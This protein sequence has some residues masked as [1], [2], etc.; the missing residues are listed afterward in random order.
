MHRNQQNIP[1]GS[2]ATS[3]FILLNAIVLEQGFV[4]H[5]QWYWLLFFTIPALLIS[6][7]VFRRGEIKQ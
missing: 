7:G 4:T 3:L 2:L 5:N 1:K 6:Q